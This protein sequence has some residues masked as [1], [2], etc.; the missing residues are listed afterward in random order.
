MCKTVK[1]WNYFLQ[2]FTRL[3]LIVLS[4]CDTH[5]WNL[6]NGIHNACWLSFRLWLA[7]SAADMSHLSVFFFFETGAKVSTANMGNTG[8]NVICVY[9]NNWLNQDD[10]IS[11]ERTIRLVQIQRSWWIVEEGRRM[12]DVKIVKPRSYCCPG[13]FFELEFSRKWLC[14]I[15]YSVI[16]LIFVLQN[17]RWKASLFLWWLEKLLKMT[18]LVLLPFFKK[19]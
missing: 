17:D 4:N 3:F 9:N 19:Q 1:G 18:V 5:T 10:V 6:F 16:F 8:S 13:F 15:K 11:I 14:P 12:V 7:S 2:I